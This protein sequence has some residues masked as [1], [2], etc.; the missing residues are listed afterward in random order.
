MTDGMAD[1]A[2]LAATGIGLGILTMGAMVPIKIMKKSLEEIEDER[3]EKDEKPV[4]RNGQKGVVLPKIRV[5]PRKVP[6]AEPYEFNAK[7][8]MPDIKINYP[9][10]KGMKKWKF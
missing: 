9:T 8:M 4:K 7:V 1:A 6:R 3:N 2:N 10:V 5:T